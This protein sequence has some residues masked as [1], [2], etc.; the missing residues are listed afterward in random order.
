MSDLDDLDF[1]LGDDENSPAETQGERIAKHLSRAGVCSRRKAEELIAEGR[2]A[3]NGEVI[4]TP[5]IRVLP[6]DEIFVDGKTIKKPDDTRLWLLHK[7]KGTVTTSSDPE[8]RRTVFDLLPEDMPRVISIGRLDLNSEGLLLL[9]NDG[10][11]SRYMELPATGW[12][13]RYRVRVFGTPSKESLR[14]LK[15]GMVI[16][17][18][19]Y[20]SV[21]A[22]IDS[23][24]GSNC[25]L[26]VALTEGK[27]REI[28]RLFEALGHEVSRLI[29]VSYGPFQLGNLGHGEVKEV[30]KKVLK[31]QLGDKFFKNK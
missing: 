31:S 9:T 27:N 8:G 1:D 30:P 12:T 24:Q 22:S 15:K 16:D 13:R 19:H 4:D 21:A 26:N 23:E 6:D 29:R 17:D 5:A 10:E 7:P 3:V 14:L 28:R 25:W 11:L 2:V 20:G 18:I